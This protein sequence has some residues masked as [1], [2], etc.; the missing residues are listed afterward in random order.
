[1]AIKDWST[2]ADNNNAA[3][4]DGYPEGMLPSA[5]NNADRET[6]AQ[7]RGFY[8]DSQWINYG[9]EATRASAITFTING[10]DLTAQYAADRAIKVTDS[11]DL[12]GYVVSSSV[13]AS[14]TTVTVELEAGSLTTSMNGSNVSLGSIRPTNDGLPKN[15]KY[16]L[17]TYAAD[18]GSTDAYVVTLSPTPVSLETG[19]EI[20]FKATNANTGASTLNVNSIGAIT[21]KKNND[22]DLAIGDIEATQIVKVIYDG[23][24]FQMVSQ[25]GNSISFDTPLAVVASA[26]SAAEIR[27]P[28]DTDNGS[29]YI[30]IKS[31]PAITTTTTFILPDGDGTSGQVQKTDGS[32]TLSWTTPYG[33]LVDTQTASSSATITFINLSS[34]YFSYMVIAEGVRPTNDGSEVLLRTSSDNGSS[35]DSG[36]SDY[37]WLTRYTKLDVSPSEVISTSPSDSV[38]K[39]VTGETWG[40]ATNEE[41]SFELRIPN[42]SSAF[43]TRVYFDGSHPNTSGV[44]VHF[45]GT[46]T[47]FSAG[48]VDGIQILGPFDA[49][50]FKLYGKRA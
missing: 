11:S 41:G 50:I 46:G 39:I 22:V 26:S 6:Q 17:H 40:N 31:P 49:G 13:S 12:Y 30:G 4:P 9:E 10:Q 32:A 1:M 2:N 18:S 27:L 8:E 42:P 23:T 36:V 37:N 34:D 16:G 21:I 47:R 5:V 20:K 48:A 33:E 7:V 24:N 14:L 3:P 43:Y 15:Y 28:E 44:D 35:Y 45:F 29:N 25:T 19:M 38:I